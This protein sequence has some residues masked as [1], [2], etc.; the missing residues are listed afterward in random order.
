[1][2]KVVVT[3]YVIKPKVRRPGVHAKNASKGQV[4]YKKKYRGQGK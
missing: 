4:A 1:M 2:A 3:K